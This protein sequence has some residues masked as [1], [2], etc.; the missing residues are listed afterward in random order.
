MDIINELNQSELGFALGIKKQI[1]NNEIRKR[2]LALGM[3][4]KDFAKAIGISFSILH[5][6]ET[7]KRY[8]K[9]HYWKSK[10]NKEH[11]SDVYMEAGLKLVKYLNV[12]FEILFPEWLSEYE[13]KT[14]IIESE[15]KITTK[16]LDSPEILQLTDPRSLDDWVD[17]KLLRKQVKE[18]LETLSEREKQV[19]E[20]RY[21]LNGNMPHTLRETGQILKNKTTKKLGISTERMRQIEAKA[22]R[23]LRHPS[24]ADKLKFYVP[25]INI[26]YCSICKQ[27]KE[28]F[29]SDWK[30]KRLFCPICKTERQFIRSLSF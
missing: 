17:K 21:G 16:Q 13:V 29:N 23:K 12:P 22:L 26:V 18:E 4:Q 27:K 11:T 25:G 5:D 6:F 7:F 14:S 28:I 1:F 19:L 10:S 8:P 24:R 15:I 2:R 9:V 20:I 30:N 3:N